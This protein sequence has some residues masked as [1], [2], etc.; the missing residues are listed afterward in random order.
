MVPGG[1]GGG[2]GGG[3]GGG[4]GSEARQGGYF[5]T[6]TIP[7]LPTH[8]LPPPLQPTINLPSEVKNRYG[9][10]KNSL[11][12]SASVMS[13][14][15]MRKASASTEGGGDTYTIGSSSG[16]NSPVMSASPSGPINLAGHHLLPQG[17]GGGGLP[18]SSSTRN[19]LMRP[20]AWLGI[21]KSKTKHREYLSPSSSVDDGVSP[22]T[23][24]HPTGG[25]EKR[26]RGGSSR[27]GGDGVM[28]LGIGMGMGMGMGPQG[29]FGGIGME[30]DRD[31]YPAMP[32]TP[33]RGGNG[34]GGGGKSRMSPLGRRE[35]GV[36]EERGMKIP[37]T[38]SST[39]MMTMMMN[40]HPGGNGPTPKSPGGRSLF[41]RRQVN[42]RWW[43]NKR[44]TRN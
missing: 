4:I 43:S 16:P 23:L 29:G 8:P 7:P 28:G 10:R 15:L 39:S 25:G 11:R 21:G 3:I 35:D 12:P 40:P 27:P 32:A 26:A 36:M 9:M 19:F 41:G 24:A 17:S 38:T 6:S 33:E 34:G 31:R 18:T 1:G 44:R 14:S 42:G 20:V 30:R 13:L 5:A 22:L 37:V 2:D